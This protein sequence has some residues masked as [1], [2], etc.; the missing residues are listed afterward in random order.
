MVV[1][2]P[3]ISI[4]NALNTLHLEHLALPVHLVHL[5]RL[6]TSKEIYMCMYV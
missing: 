6:G 2:D 4:A 1:T 3:S 5:G